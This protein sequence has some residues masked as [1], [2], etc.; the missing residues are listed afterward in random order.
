MCINIEDCGVYRI[1][2]LVTEKVYVGS[3]KNIKV[4]I[5]SHVND[6]IRNKHTN[7]HLQFAWVK[8]GAESFR[9]EVLEYCERDRRVE[10]EQYYIN[11]YNSA[12]VGYNILP[13]AGS[14]F[15]RKMSEEARKKMSLAKKGKPSLRRGKTHSEES[16]RKMSISSTNPSDETRQKMSR[17]KKGKTGNHTGIPH[18]EESKQKMSLSKKGRKSTRKNYTASLETREKMS[19][20]KRTPHKLENGV[21]LKYC[22]GCKCWLTL[23]LFNK[24][25]NKWDGLVR[26]CRKC[27]NLYYGREVVV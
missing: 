21:E 17:A 8:Y 3:S 18:S 23:D 9:F 1:F 13:T 27:V 20:L 2:N 26:R 7:R 25:S 6:L 12:E 5:D 4:R 16:K 10:R 11:L 24:D 19:K 14:S 22:S 15:G